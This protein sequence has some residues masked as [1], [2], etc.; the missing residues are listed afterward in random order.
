MADGSSPEALYRILLASG[1]VVSV[2]V[3]GLL[4]VGGVSAFGV[5]AI[6][7]LGFFVYAYWRA[8]GKR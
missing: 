8:R 5:L 6:P 2:V 4:V 1:I 7:A 3:I